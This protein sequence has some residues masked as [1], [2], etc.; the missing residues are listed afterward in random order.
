MISSIQE[1]VPGSFPIPFFQTW[2][3]ERSAV[4][5]SASAGVGIW[6]ELESAGL[7]PKM[8]ECVRD[9]LV[10]NRVGVD[11]IHYLFNDADCRDFVAR[12][13]PPDVLMAYDR[14][15]PTAFKADLWRYCVLYKYGGVYLDVKYGGGSA[16]RRRELRSGGSAPQR[17]EL[18]SGGSAP[19]RR[20]LRSIDQG[21][22]PPPTAVALNEP[23]QASIMLRD[24]VERFFGGGGVGGVGV[25]GVGVGVGGVGVGGVGVGGVG[26]VGGGGGG[27]GVGGGDGVGG[28]GGGGGVGGVGDGGDVFVLERDAVGLWPPGHHGI[29]NAFMIVRPK[30][31]ILLECIY[32]IVSAAK[33]GW[34]ARGGLDDD[35]SAGWMTRPLFVTGPGLLGD[36]WREGP[37]VVPDSYAT[38]APYFRFFFE[39]DGVIGYY[40][41]DDSYVQI[42]K[43]YDGYQDEYRHMMSHRNCV[44]HYTVLWARGVV[45]GGE[46]CPP[47]RQI[48]RG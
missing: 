6:S 19:Q 9:N 32:R 21:G 2:C 38:M 4:T 31:P 26:G 41:D 44:P 40:N 14:L 36:V 30:N 39:G 34:Y 25:G 33:N 29:H 22:V 12:E 23:A 46:V 17:R 27:G 24:I 15:M 18:R 28:V 7:P 42:F 35:Y 10:L 5:P 20:E 45:W 48:M 16:Q 37:V 3:C 8:I 11:C 1:W 47:L 43:V 13:Y